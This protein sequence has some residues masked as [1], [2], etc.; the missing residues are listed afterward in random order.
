MTPRFRLPGTSTE[1]RLHLPAQTLRLGGGAIFALAIQLIAIFAPLGDD[2]PRRALML[3]S[4]IILIGFVSLNLRRIGMVII[5]IGLLLNF[6]PIVANGGLMPVTPETLA[7][8]DFPEDVRP[9]DWVPGSKDVLLEEEDVRLWAL[10]DRFVVDGLGGTIAYSPGDIFIAVGVVVLLGELLL[11]RIRRA[12]P[13]G[14]PPN[15]HAAA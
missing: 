11:P 1:V 10:G 5:G 6:L 3:L 13:N 15:N 9:G 2:V 8:G 12:E 7:R 4:Y 14:E